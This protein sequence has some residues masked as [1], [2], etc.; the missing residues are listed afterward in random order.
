MSDECDD[1]GVVADLEYDQKI[2]KKEIAELMNKVSN[3]KEKLSDAYSE[4]DE[5]VDSLKGTMRD[6]DI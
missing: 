2:Y 3:L 5:I 4:L 6:I 1:C